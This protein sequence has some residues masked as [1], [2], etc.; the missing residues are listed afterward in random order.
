MG[1]NCQVLKKYDQFCDKD[2]QLYMYNIYNYN[3]ITLTRLDVRWPSIFAWCFFDE[4]GSN[5]SGF[6][7][8]TCRTA[9]IL[10]R[11]DHLQST[12]AAHFHNGLGMGVSDC[13]MSS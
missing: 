2:A 9:W 6:S 8:L 11:N 13:S 10:V 3:Y 5:K 7:R 4:E 1:E 12:S